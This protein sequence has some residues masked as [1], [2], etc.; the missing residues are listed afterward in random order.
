M[1]EDLFGYFFRARR[2]MFL[3]ILHALYFYWQHFVLPSSPPQFLSNIH[4]YS[5]LSAPSIFRL[6]L[7]H[8]IHAYSTCTVYPAC[9]SSFHYTTLLGL[10]SRE[11]LSNGGTGVLPLAL[12]W[13]ELRS[14]LK[15]QVYFMWQQAW[16]FSNTGPTTNFFL[17][18]VKEKAFF[19]L[20]LNF[21]L[22]QA[23]PRYGFLCKY[24]FHFHLRSSPLC[25]CYGDFQD[26]FHVL[27]YF[28]RFKNLRPCFQNFIRVV[29][30]FS[31][32][33]FAGMAIRGLWK[34][35]HSLLLLRR[36]RRQRP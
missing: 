8:H 36:R 7:S 14:L 1:K 13:N 16:D 27:Y 3:G 26:S 12:S 22:T 29:L 15:K 31:F 32:T 30:S 21:F 20:D 25:P 18:L 19:P 11:W 10:V 6:Y 9:H 5:H 4:I 2:I 24:L 35:E 33:K 23:H 17:P 28:P 34:E